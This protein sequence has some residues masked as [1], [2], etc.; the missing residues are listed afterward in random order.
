MQKYKEM[1]TI[2]INENTPQT[3]QFVKF[4]RTLPFAT[5]SE[6]KVKTKSVWETA[7]EEGAV[8]VDEFVDEL[9]RQLREHYKNA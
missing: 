4:V 5:V 6:D 7:I 1:T 8:T 3:R 2:V 9:Q